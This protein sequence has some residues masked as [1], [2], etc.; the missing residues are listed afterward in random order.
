MLSIENRKN[1]LSNFCKDQE[2]NLHTDSNLDNDEAED[3]E[4]QKN[5]IIR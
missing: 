5:K 3:K 4:K 2:I 1:I